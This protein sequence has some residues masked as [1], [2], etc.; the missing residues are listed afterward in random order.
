M[1][2]SYASTVLMLSAFSFWLLAESRVSCRSDV[3]LSVVVGD[4]IYA[5]IDV[6]FLNVG[7]YE[8]KETLLLL[9]WTTDTGFDFIFVI[10]AVFL[11][12]DWYAL[13]GLCLLKF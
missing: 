5:G 9:D 13:V 10:G 8:L 2:F 4:L 12:K 1:G 7:L 6:N 11:V 3:C